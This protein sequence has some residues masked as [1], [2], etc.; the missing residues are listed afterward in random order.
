MVPG[1]LAGGIPP[2]LRDAPMTN[3]RFAVAS[4][5][6]LGLLALVPTVAATDLE[7][8]RPPW[9]RPNCSATVGDLDGDGWQDAEYSCWTPPPCQYC[10]CT[11]WGA[12]LQV[13]ALGQEWDSVS[14]VS[15]SAGTRG[16][17]DGGAPDLE[18]PTCVGYD[19]Y[20]PWSPGPITDPITQ[21]FDLGFTLD[22]QDPVCAPGQTLCYAAVPSDA[23]TAPT[24]VH[25]GTEDYIMCMCAC[26][27]AGGG[28][29][30]EAAGQRVDGDGAV[31]VPP[32]CGFRADATYTPAPVDLDQPTCVSAH[33]W[34]WPPS[35][36][37]LTAAIDQPLP[38]VAWPPCVDLIEPQPVVL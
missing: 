28:V 4:L 34:T 7:I 12:G 11:F 37:D 21:A 6:L 8:G 23:T 30:V 25:C 16:S 22:L 13:S 18:A 20:T 29:D 33:V 17:V 15:C 14:G 26:P 24:T 27:V 31:V 3:A 35:Y 9:P 32:F 1:W 2:P 38:P 5:G 19:T 36:V 10:I